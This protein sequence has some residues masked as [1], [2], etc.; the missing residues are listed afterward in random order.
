MNINN[1]VYDLNTLPLFCNI[2]IRPIIVRI[3]LIENIAKYEEP[4]WYRH[5]YHTERHNN[6]MELN[7]KLEKIDPQ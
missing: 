1:N 7:L 2:N 3:R 6:Y 5:L 4:N